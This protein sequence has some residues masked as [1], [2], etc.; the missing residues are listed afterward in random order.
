MDDQ[1]PSLNSIINLIFN[2]FLELGCRSQT[3][4]AVGNFNFIFYIL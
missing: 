4:M 2:Y 1:Q 3:K